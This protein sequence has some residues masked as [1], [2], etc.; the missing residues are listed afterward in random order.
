[1]W[2]ANTA[3]AAMMIPIVTAVLEELKKNKQESG[4]DNQFRDLRTV[5]CFITGGSLGREI[6]WSLYTAFVDNV[7]APLEVSDKTTEETTDFDAESQKSTAPAEVV[8]DND[9][10]NELSLVEKGMILCVPYACSIG[11]TTTLTG[12]AP[13]LVLQELWQ[14]RYPDAPYSL[15]YIQVSYQ[16]FN[17]CSGAT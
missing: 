17:R 3:A 8:S 14:E 1:M 16:G 2:I 4:V 10:K 6:I 7:V 5:E 11:G 15:N 13:N 9:E 12:T